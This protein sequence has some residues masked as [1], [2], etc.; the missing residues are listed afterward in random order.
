MDSVLSS[1]TFLRKTPVTFKSINEHSAESQ[2][3]WVSSLMLHSMSRM[4]Q[5]KY[6]HFWMNPTQQ[7]ICKEVV[8]V[9]LT[10]IE[11]T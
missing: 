3:E 8:H 10:H 11:L 2:N 4:D 1:V 7:K 9:G 6:I 5:G